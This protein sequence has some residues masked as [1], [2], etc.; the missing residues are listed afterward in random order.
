L[1]SLE[2]WVKREVLKALLRIKR[3]E[4]WSLTKLSEEA[5]IPVEVVKSV[6]EDVTDSVIVKDDSVSIAEYGKVQIAILCLNLGAD[7]SYVSR[8]LD[9][10]EFEEFTAKIVDAYGYTVYKNYRFKS[11]NRRWEIDVL[12]IKKPVLLCLN[13]KHFLKQ[14]WSSLRK[15][16][17]EELERAEALKQALPRLKLEPKPSEG[18]KIL[19]ALVTLITPKSK[20]Y[21]KIPIVRITELG[22]FLEELTLYTDSLKFL[23]V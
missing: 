10:R 14:R 1:R 7:P 17:L 15:A 11:V 6:L 22:N 12:A 23:Q 20:I 8:H 2:D 3:S 21:D 5:N 19:P 18:W 16:A 13:C 4:W 9:W